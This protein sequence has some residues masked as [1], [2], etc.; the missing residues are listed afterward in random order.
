MS[1]TDNLS[2][3]ERVELAIETLEQVVEILGVLDS[4]ID[5]TISDILTAIHDAALDCEQLEFDDEGELIEP[6]EHFEDE[7][8]DEGDEDEDE[9]DEWD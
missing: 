9:D 2:D 6:D 1:N 7:D 8:E 5:P 4:A 3:Q